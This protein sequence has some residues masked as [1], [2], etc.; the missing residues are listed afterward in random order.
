MI[1]NVGMI[2]RAIDGEVDRD[3]HSP[4]L[5]LTDQPR[6]VFERSKFR[7]NILMATTVDALTI[8]ADGIGNTRFARLTGDRIVASFAGCLPMG[9][10]GG[11]Y[12]TSKPIALAS[13]ILGR[14][15]RK[16][17]PRSGLPSAERGKNL[18]RA[19]NTALP[20]HPKWQ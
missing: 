19:A 15:S 6:K 9:W 5:G 14:Q 1:V 11:K 13:S 18:Y 20:I 7:R 12:I 17:E 16:V 4:L 3:L 10:I 2:G 8:V